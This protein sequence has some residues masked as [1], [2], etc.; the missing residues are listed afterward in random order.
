MHRLTFQ[1]G[2]NLRYLGLI[3]SELEQAVE[4]EKVGSPEGSH[5][6]LYYHPSHPHY[7][8]LDKTSTRS[9]TSPNHFR[10]RSPA[11]GERAADRSYSCS[12]CSFRICSSC[13]AEG[14]ARSFLLSFGPLVLWFLTPPLRIRRRAS[15]HCL[16]SVEHCPRGP[17]RQSAKT[18]DLR[19]AEGSLEVRPRR[20]LLR[21]PPAIPNRVE[22]LPVSLHAATSIRCSGRRRCESLPTPAR[23]PSPPCIGPQPLLG[24]DWHCMY[25]FSPL[26]FPFYSTF[27]LIPIGA[28]QD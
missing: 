14:K 24:S 23:P 20:Q 28:S 16:S 21:R 6:I 15:H 22:R 26:N 13:F 27:H 9:C 10:A 11:F 25:P 1:R 18:A 17:C 8:S 2:I 7:L 5:S 4:S 12:D 19:Q 3:A